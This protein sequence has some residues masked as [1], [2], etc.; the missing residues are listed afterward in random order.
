MRTAVSG[1]EP[2]RELEGMDITC[3]R[4]AKARGNSAT[5]FSPCCGLAENIK[6]KRLPPFC[7]GF[8]RPAS[9]SS[10]SKAKKPVKETSQE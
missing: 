2:G 7:K 9:Q 6:T 4:S 3:L 8:L 1:R 5:H 10:Q